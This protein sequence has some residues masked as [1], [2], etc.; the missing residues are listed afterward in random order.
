MVRHEYAE[1]DR[2]EGLEK[3]LKGCRDVERR[4]R[5]VIPTARARGYVMVTDWEPKLKYMHPVEQATQD[6]MR[7]ALAAAGDGYQPTHWLLW[8]GDGDGDRARGRAPTP[9]EWG[10][11]WANSTADV[12]SH[13]WGHLLGN[14]HAG[15]IDANGIT[16]EYGAGDYSIMGGGDDRPSFSAANLERMRVIQA[17]QVTSGTQ[18]DILLGP[19][20]RNRRARFRGEVPAVRLPNGRILSTRTG[21]GPLAINYPY[22]VFA[23]TL[24]RDGHTLLHLAE[25]MIPGDVRSY[26]ECTVQYLAA[27]R[28]MALLRV[29]I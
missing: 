8:G 14:E 23:Q 9:G 27:E 29:T 6:A 16:I 21:Q 22:K 7:A 28:E 13:E 5:P 18:E 2:S 11:V 17:Y 20:E 4:Y 3:C 24:Q 15:T 26:P 12:L 1:A 10:S 25:T 19:V